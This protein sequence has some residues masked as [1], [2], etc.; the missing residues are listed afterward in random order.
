[1]IVVKHIGPTPTTLGGL[2]RSDSA[3]RKQFLLV[4]TVI[5]SQLSLLQ[6]SFKAF[7][8]QRHGEEAINCHKG[9]R[10]KG[11]GRLDKKRTKETGFQFQRM[12]TSADFKNWLMITGYE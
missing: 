6:L 10:H 1:M 11:G 9:C 3:Y 2:I 5:S 4:F 7:I 8:V 12:R